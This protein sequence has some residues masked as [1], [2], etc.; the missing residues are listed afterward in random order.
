[1]IYE[2]I[3]PGTPELN[4]ETDPVIGALIDIRSRSLVEG[5]IEAIIEELRWY[6]NLRDAAESIYGE[7]QI[8][9]KEI[10]RKYQ[11]L[12]DEQIED[13]IHKLEESETGD[14]INQ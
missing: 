4:E 3:L 8:V 10:H 13:L 14:Y 6:Q 2:T 5:D 12:S 11:H 1:M 9:W 7:D